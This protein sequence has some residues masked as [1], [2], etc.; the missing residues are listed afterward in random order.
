MSLAAAVNAGRQAAAVEVDG[1]VLEG[2]EGADDAFDADPGGVLEVAGYGQGGHHHGQVSPGGLTGVVEDRAARR[3]CLLIRKDGPGVPQLVIRGDNLTGIHQTGRA[4]RD[5]ALETHQRPGPGDGGLIQSGVTSVDGDKTSALRT[6]LAGDDDPGP[7]GL[8][9]QSLVAPGRAPLGV[10]PHR[11]PR[12]RVSA[13]V[14]HRLMTPADVALTPGAPSGGDGVND[15]PIGEGVP[16][17]V[18]VRLQ[19]PL[20]CWWSRTTPGPPTR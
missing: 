17:P 19:I 11:P 16:V 6:P 7:V 5:V 18:E 13:R 4:V 2:F 12:P 20:P 1:D 10:D 15:L 3:S 9:G 8:S 14:P